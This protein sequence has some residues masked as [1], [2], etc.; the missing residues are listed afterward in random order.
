MPDALPFDES[1]GRAAFER[2]KG[3]AEA[4]PKEQRKRPYANLK[5]AALKTLAAHR[6]AEAAGVRADLAKLPSELWELRHYD[7]LPA[8]AWACWFV[9]EQ[10]DLASATATSAKVSLEAIEEARQRRATMLDVLDYNLLDQKHVQLQLKTIRKGAGYA[11]LAKDLFQ[12]ADLYKTH[13]D[14]LT[15]DVRRYRP[16]DAQD[17]RAQAQRIVDEMGEPADGSWLDWSWRF[18]AL[19]TEAYEQTQ[20][21]VAFVAH[22]DQERRAIFASL[23]S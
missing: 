11:D 12:L 7:D 3:R 18:W 8:L 2:L 10:R 16:Q 1:A 9:Y 21:A 15:L 5:D 13:Q 19:L 17:A 14:A 6:E 23:R 4:L 22:E 20:R